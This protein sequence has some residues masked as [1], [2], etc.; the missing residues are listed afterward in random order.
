MMICQE[1]VL[2]R[3]NSRYKNSEAGMSFGYLKIAR[4]L[5]CAK[6]YRVQDLWS[7]RK[8]DRKVQVGISLYMAYMV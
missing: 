2:G 5:Y 4:I 1:H 7:E 6:K 8:N 3:A